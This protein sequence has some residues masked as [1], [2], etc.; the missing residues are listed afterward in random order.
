[1][2]KKHYY[3]LVLTSLVLILIATSCYNK[4]PDTDLADLDV[5]ITYYD[6]EFDFSLYN[7]FAIRDSVGLIQ[8]NMTDEQIAEF[9]EEGGA[10]EKIREY[11]KQAFIDLGYQYLENDSSFDFG[12]NPVVVLVENTATV[13]YPGFWWGYPGYSGWYGGWWYPYY[14]WYPPTYYQVYNFKTGTIMVEMADGQSMRDYWEWIDGKTDEELE[15]ANPADIPP[16]KYPWTALV[17][18]VVS[19]DG[20]HNGETAERG[21]REAIN[22]SPYLQK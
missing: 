16:V 22:Q 1:M 20:K 10:S 12:I 9:Y 13:N 5:T 21:F 6:T 18:G 3:K 4:Q 7:T 14:G 2:K 19:Q 15:N 11:W 17:N 8:D